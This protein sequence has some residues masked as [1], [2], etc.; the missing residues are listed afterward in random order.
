[1]TIEGATKPEWSDAIKSAPGGGCGVSPPN[2][3]RAVPAGYARPAYPSAL[4]N[5]IH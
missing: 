5:L 1:M 4:R 2:S 3:S